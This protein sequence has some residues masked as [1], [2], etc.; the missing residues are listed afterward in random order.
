[1]I[2]VGDIMSTLV[3]Y[4]EYT[5]DVQYTGGIPWNTR[6]CSVHLRDTMS[7]PGNTMS[8]PGTFIQTRESHY[9]TSK[10]PATGSSSASKSRLR[11][12]EKDNFNRLSIISPTNIVIIKTIMDTRNFTGLSCLKSL[13]WTPL[14]ACLHSSRNA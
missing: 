6:G 1:M 10:L 9:Q 7:T 5:R 13:S 8:T 2:S 12:P 14:Q 11:I 4:H 3:G